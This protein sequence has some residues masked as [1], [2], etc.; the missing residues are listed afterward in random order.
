MTST[1]L[2]QHASNL[3]DTTIKAFN[4]DETSI[5][6]IDS[7]SLIDS[8]I[9]LLHDSDQSA[10]SIADGLSSLKAELQSGN[11]DGS[12][13]QHILNDLVGQT[14]QVADLDGIQTET[15]VNALVE[16]LQGFSQQ[17]N[18]SSKKANTGGQAPMTSTVGGESTNSGTGSS[19][20]NS[21]DDALSGRNGGTISNTPTAEQ[22]QEP[23]ETST[24][25]TERSSGTS[26]GDEGDD[27][28]S[29]TTR[30]SRSDSSRVDGPG[31][32]GGTGDTDSTQSGGRSQY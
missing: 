9:S 26:N 18:G 24:L 16:A 32:S 31:I 29:S 10:H 19:S 1:A 28:Y 2:S 30:K 21:N 25:T 11:P 20:L 8:W 27:S 13:I 4:G 23:D 17:L 22:N 12:Q 7:I 14:K 5:S 3:V 15:K 6:I